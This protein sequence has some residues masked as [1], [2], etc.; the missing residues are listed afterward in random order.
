MA[1]TWTARIRLP[2]CEDHQRPFLWQGTYFAWGLVAYFCLATAVIC[3]ISEIDRF[4]ADERLS[5]AMP[6]LGIGAIGWV[7]GLFLL[8]RQA[9][10]A[11]Q[12]TEHSLTLRGISRT[13]IDALHGRTHGRRQDESDGQ[14]D[15]PEC[16]KPFD[17]HA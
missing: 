8:K 2:L 9:L 11:I 1:N 7:I 3:L 17:P 10:Q 15:Q 4:A 12:I 6:L 13:F 16:D 5:V 14:L